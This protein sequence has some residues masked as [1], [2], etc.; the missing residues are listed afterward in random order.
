MDI[1]DE[2]VNLRGIE[3]GRIDDY[4]LLLVAQCALIPDVVEIVRSESSEFGVLLVGFEE[5]GRFCVG[6]DGVDVRRRP[7]S[8]GGDESVAIQ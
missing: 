3:I 4:G 8:A 2:V 1:E 5:V 6:R 7:D